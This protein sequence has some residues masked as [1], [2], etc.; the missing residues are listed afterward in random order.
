MK[1]ESRAAG[2]HQLQMK[3]EVS[4]EKLERSSSLYLEGHESL[5]IEEE[6]DQVKEEEED[7]PKISL[8]IGNV[9]IQ[10]DEDENTPLI[11]SLSHHIKTE[12]GVDDCCGPEPTPY[13]DTHLHSEQQRSPFSESDTDDSRDCRETSTS[14]SASNSV[15]NSKVHVTEKKIDDG[16]KSL[17]CPGCGRKCSSKSGLTQHMQSCSGESLTCSFCGK[18]FANRQYLK[19]HVR[20]H[21]GEKPFA[22][23]LC[24]KCFTQ[25]GQLRGHM[26][27]HAGEKPFICS[28]CD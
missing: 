17:G 4:P 23:S 1:M 3:E 22:C 19:I 2:V 6:K 10:E 14:H 21:T 18:H 27:I 20:I 13:L 7:F 15:E 11:C 16:H 28:Q 12:A 5:F 25:R 8:T 9:K 26:R 24:G